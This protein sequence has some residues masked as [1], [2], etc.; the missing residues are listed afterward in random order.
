MS[1]S[2][3]PLEILRHLRKQYSN[4]IFIAILYVLKTYPS[5]VV[6]RKPKSKLAYRFRVPFELYLL[7]RLLDNGFELE[8][9]GEEN[10]TLRHEESGTRIRCQAGSL[11]SLNEIYVNRVYGDDFKGA[12]VID[13]GMYNGDSSLYFA[14]RG[15]RLVL[16]LEPNRKSFEIAL[17]NMMMNPH[18]KAVVPLNTSIQPGS[19]SETHLELRAGEKEQF[20]ALTRHGITLGEAMERYGID[21]VDVLKV[22]CE[23]C[24]YEL[25]HQTPPEVLCKI[26]TIILEF[27]DGATRLVDDFR[28]AGFSV[29]PPPNGPVGILEAHSQKTTW[30]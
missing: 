9:N 27:H 6:L 22:D 14:A 15:A 2:V 11:Y 7:A 3:N 10:I 24:E 17:Q 13:V 29:K 5:K 12:V 30:A 25:I 16:G 8:A 26:R 28:K 18:G 19:R 4:W 21:H 23:G 1:I 20:D